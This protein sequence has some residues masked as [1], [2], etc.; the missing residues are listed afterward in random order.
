MITASR[1]DVDR[2]VY[3]IQYGVDAASAVSGDT[4]SAK[5]HNQANG[6]KS[7]YTGANDGKFVVTVAKGYEG[8]DDVTITGSDGGEATGEVT[9]G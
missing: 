8:T 4:I 9:F 7:V 5:F 2:D 3:E 1:L 6:D